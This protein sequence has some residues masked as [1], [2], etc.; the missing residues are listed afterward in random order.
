[1]NIEVII[2]C[3]GYCDFLAITLPETKHWFTAITVITAPEDLETIA[4]AKF[5]GVSLYITSVWRE[6]G[7]KFNKAAAI[8]SFLDQRA[9]DGTDSWV[10]FLDADILIQ[11]DLHPDIV[12]LNPQGL[13]SIK[14]RMCETKEEW[15]ELSTGQRCVDEMPLYVPAVVNGKVWKHRP[16]DN[17]A[18]LSGYLQLWHVTKSVGLKRLPASPNAANY[19]VLFAFSFPDALRSYIQGREVLHLGPR[20]TNWDG[21]VSPRWNLSAAER[22]GTLIWS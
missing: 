15:L 16:T 11:T 4:L 6:N 3:V 20:N 13:Y 12:A 8:N 21:R 17:P 7:A 22:S 14:R 9:L 10:L 19:D 2:T 5:E 1:M 18:A